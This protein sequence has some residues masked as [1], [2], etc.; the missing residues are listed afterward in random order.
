MTDVW[1][2]GVLVLSFGSVFA[3]GYAVNGL[4]DGI[5]EL[6]RHW[7]SA[8]PVLG[9]FMAAGLATVGRYKRGRKATP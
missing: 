1:R 6:P 4:A 8:A 5:T 2:V 3:L 9:L 7:W